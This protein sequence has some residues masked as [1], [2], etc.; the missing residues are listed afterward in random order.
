MKE[1][2]SAGT[3]RVSS[4]RDTH[5]EAA[6]FVIEHHYALLEAVAM[7][8]GGYELYGREVEL[9]ARWDKVCEVAG[10]QATAFLAKPSFATTQEAVG[11]V[12]THGTFVE[13]ARRKLNEMKALCTT[14]AN[15]Y[16]QTSVQP[17]DALSLNE[18]ALL[19]T[20]RC[21]SRMIGPDAYQ[22]LTR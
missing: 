17:V 8:D 19:R 10:K 14:G 12:Q 5:P 3:E 13:D 15:R 22:A 4:L 11:W 1:R 21:A 16:R 7:R 9:L 2:S 6:A 20:A 18:E